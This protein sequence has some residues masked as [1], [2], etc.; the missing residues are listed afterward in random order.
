MKLS[1]IQRTLSCG[2]LAFVLAACSGTQSHHLAGTA[3]APGADAHLEVEPESAGNNLLR[4][5]VANLLPPNR[6]DESATTYAVWLEPAER[7][8]VH[9]GNL[10]YDK[11]ERSGELATSTPHKLFK[12]TV[13]AEVERT[14]ERPSGDVVLSQDVDL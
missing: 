1:L 3:K 12:L 2:A 4:L 9:V 5:E 13:T 8:A 11:K 7:A 6:V 14:P 10:K